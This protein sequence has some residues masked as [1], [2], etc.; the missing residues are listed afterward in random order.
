MIFKK[1]NDQKF[2]LNNKEYQIKNGVDFHLSKNG[3]RITFEIAVKGGG[4]DYFDF[5]VSEFQ[6]LVSENYNGDDS[7]RDFL[8]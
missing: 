5:M 8:I 4:C 3:R 6:N 2:S 7:P 1:I